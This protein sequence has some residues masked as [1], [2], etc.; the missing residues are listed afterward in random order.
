MDEPNRGLDLKAFLPSTP[1]FQTLPPAALETLVSAAKVRDFPAEETLLDPAG[2]PPEAL[3]LIV[4]GGVRVI[5]PR[6]GRH[7]EERVLDLRGEREI[8]C[9]L[10]LLGNRPSP[11]R[12]VTEGETRCILLPKGPFLN[13]LEEFPEVLLEFGVG[14]GRGPGGEVGSG[15][16]GRGEAKGGL[17]GPDPLQFSS[18]VRDFMHRHVITCPEDR[19]VVEAARQMTQKGVGSLLVVD[20]DGAPVGMLT[21]GDLRKKI[22]ASGSLRDLPVAQVMNTP[23]LFLSPEAFYF[24]AVLFM[25]RNRIKVL[26]VMEGGA[27]LGILSERDLVI[28]QGN[29]PVG[30]IRD[31]QQALDVEELVRIRQEINR[32]LRVML[33]RGGRT[34]EICQL[35]TQLNDHLTLRILHLAE[36][37]MVLKGKGRPPVAYAWMALG[38]EGR[39]EQTLSTDQDNA[40]VFADSDPQGEEMARRYFLVLSKYV[41]SGLERCGFPRCNG[42]MMA[43]NPKWCQPL[44]VWKDYYR[45][46]IF[47]RE[48]SA[49]DILIS[50]IFFDFRQIWGDE[51]LI[52]ALRET[53]DQ[54]IPES[55]VF[56]PHMAL[57]SLELQPPL[58]FFNRLVVEKSGE[59]KDSI[60][61][62]LH[63]LMP[64]IDAI[65]ILA[66]EQGIARTNTLER[67]EGLVEKGVFTQSEGR[68]LGEAF[69]FLM[70]LR[71]QHHLARMKEGLP[72]DNYVQPARLSPIRRSMLKSSFKTIGQLQRQLETRFGLTVF[73]K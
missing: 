64:L 68:D 48:L 67:L 56:L 58:G 5:A 39:Q 73:R 54:A 20:R 31:I 18:K 46:W 66:M 14:G 47:Q 25:I 35:I 55:K 29:N 21:D 3:Y 24:E 50:S 43:T 42:G 72:L 51:G 6:K 69:N 63:G 23:L 40:L 2:P 45:K 65:R 9:L 59:H 36:E 27:L 70:L 34:R 37:A 15:P 32:T 19:T 38:S 71:F 26:P 7:T 13:L 49:Q 60:N 10:S 41:V 1:P 8:F 17:D 28:S 11:F 62:K 52:Q 57:R 44:H 12:F 61:I 16:N 33:E 30:I 4:S 22:V 53:V